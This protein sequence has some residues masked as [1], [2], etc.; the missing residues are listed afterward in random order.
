MHTIKS[1]VGMV[2][3]LFDFIICVIFSGMIRFIGPSGE[4]ELVNF[5]WFPSLVIWRT[6]IHKININFRKRLIIKGASHSNHYNNMQ[7]CTTIFLLK[8]RHENNNI[9]LVSPNF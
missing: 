1:S 3:V 2:C 9:A 5:Y 7:E 4:I 6:S 8:I